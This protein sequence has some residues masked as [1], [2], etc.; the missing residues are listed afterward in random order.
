MEKTKILI[1]ACD[2]YGYVVSEILNILLNVFLDDVDILGIDLKYSTGYSEKVLT[3][4]IPKLSSEEIIKKS[5]EADVFFSLSYPIIVGDE[6]LSNCRCVNWHC[7]KLPEYK[8]RSMF[9]R[10][11]IN[12]EIVYGTTFHI[13][14][15]DL[16]TGNILSERLLPIEVSDTALT[17]RKKAENA[18]IAM[19]IIL[20]QNTTRLVLVDE[21]LHFTFFFDYQY[22]SLLILLIL[23]LL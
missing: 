4:S 20:S 5:K 21:W 9:S 10:A 18:T 8:G 3:N 22:I 7:A 14:D 19:L 6:I 17:L 16:D 2:N 12:R 13:M 11:I 1:G 15:K 23:I